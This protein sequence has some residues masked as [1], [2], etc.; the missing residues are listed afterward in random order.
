M[1][2][3]KIKNSDLKNGTFDLEDVPQGT[4]KLYISDCRDLK[5]LP[6][7][8][9]FSALHISRCPNLT[10]LPKK[11]KVGSLDLSDCTGLTE[12][13]DNLKVSDGIRLT[14]CTGLTS[15]PQKLKVGN[16]DLSGC[17]GLTSLSKKLK[18][19][20]DLNLSGC[21]GLTSLPDNLKMRVSLNLSGCTGLTSLPDNLNSIHY[22][23][24]KGCASLTKLPDNLNVIN[25]LDLK[26]CTGI[27]KLSDNLNVMGKLNLSGCTKLTSLPDNLQAR[28][29]LDLSNCTG[30][31]PTP[32]L[33][34][35]LESLERTNH[36]TVVIWPKH[37]KRGEAI[38]LAKERLEAVITNYEK[39][40]EGGAP[41]TSD[42]FHRFLS[43]GLGQRDGAAAVA[44][45]V[46]SF[47][48]FIEKDSK[49]LK[50]IEPIAS[51]F[52]EGCV[53]QPVAGFSEISAWVAIAEKQNTAAKLE[54]ARQLI[55]LEA[56]KD[57]VANCDP[58]P[59]QEVEVEAGNALLR[60]VH[61][62]LVKSGMKP[63]P[64][65]PGSVTYEVTIKSWLTDENIVEATKRA[66]TSN[67]KPLADVADYLLSVHGDT[68]ATV[69]FPVETAAIAAKQTNKQ[70]ALGELFVDPTTPYKADSKNP[71]SAAVMAEINQYE[72]ALKGMSE[73]E[74][75]AK[76]EE[77]S[78]ELETEKAT[79]TGEIIRKLTLDA[80]QQSKKP[81]HFRD[82]ISKG[83]EREK[84]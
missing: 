44:E 67:G 75:V 39:T 69:A 34:A 56:I 16:L 42:L 68:W 66:A 18:V 79:G 82:M 77:L 33:I 24:L 23:N 31:I 71:P 40:T 50:W 55:A 17:T 72:A 19:L 51:G 1:R 62:N 84:F 25:N 10:S 4:N 6:D 47:L 30:L 32:E 9:K 59:G 65:V 57:F 52:L 36:N 49:H 29:R 38:D 63:W 37:F 26:D 48:Q 11:L 61:K 76:L 53:N 12:L 7:K 28:E 5:S 20:Y 41:S 8:L 35:K 58:K 78:K 54:A 21:T 74:R 3:F 22:L 14:G 81:S 80:I 46:D 27:V 45:G 60:E 43:E 70:E 13:P 2:E 64:G 15:L 83:P 73:K